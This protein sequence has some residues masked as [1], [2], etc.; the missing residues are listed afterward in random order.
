MRKKSSDD[1]FATG[2]YFSL[3]TRILTW[4]TI[5]TRPQYQNRGIGDKRERQYAFVP[6]AMYCASGVLFT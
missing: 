4:S 2:R 6:F 3:V 1:L 5:T